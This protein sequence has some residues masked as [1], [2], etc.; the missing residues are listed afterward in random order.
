MRRII[1]LFT[2][3]LKSGAAIAHDSC[4]LRG[5]GLEHDREW[6]LVDEEGTFVSQRTFPALARVLP[7]VTYDPDTWSTRISFTVRN[8]D[9]RD[10]PF[11]PSPEFIRHDS[12]APT[13]PVRVWDSTVDAHDHGDV[14]AE[15]FGDLL[16][17]RVRLV[18]IAPDSRRPT[19]RDANVEVGFADGYPLLVTTQ[20]SL[21]DLNA[22]LADPVG[23]DRFRPSV[24]V[25]GCKRPYEEDEWDAFRLAGVPIVGVKR[26][27]RCPV[28]QTDQSE[29]RRAGAEPTKTL[30]T[31]R[32]TVVQENGKPA[33]KTWFGINANH[34]GNGVLAIGDPVLV[35][36][37]GN[38]PF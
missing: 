15:W 35:E 5:R 30:L 4:W 37:F 1:G 12:K 10:N 28:I 11:A 19:S 34:Q 16:G 7:A 25:S 38:V 8:Q 18:Q 14:A 17:A 22:R 26:C 32:R 21:D 6:M 13:R 36:R 20:E 2:Y 33:T 24:L 3:P 27:V 31:Y 23:A 29:G 9:A